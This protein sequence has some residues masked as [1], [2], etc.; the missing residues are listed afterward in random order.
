MANK[1]SAYDLDD[2]E[3][4]KYNTRSRLIEESLEMD[5][6]RV[7]G[8][9]DHMN[10]NPDLYRKLRGAIAIGAVAKILIDSRKG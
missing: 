9:S 4:N 2:I 3:E 6:D 1:F 7:R 10:Q 8:E 5:L